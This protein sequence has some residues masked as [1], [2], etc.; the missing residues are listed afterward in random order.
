[1][2]WL[3]PNIEGAGQAFAEKVAKGGLVVGYSIVVMELM[4]VGLEGAENIIL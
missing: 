2:V 1:M 3:Q 4:K